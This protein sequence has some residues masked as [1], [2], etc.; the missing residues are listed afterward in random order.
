M[1]R[2]V[3]TLLTSGCSHAL[4]V[5][6][7]NEEP[8]SQRP[9]QH[10]GESQPPRSTLAMAVTRHSVD[11][12]RCTYSGA[13]GA[14]INPA[15]CTCG[16]QQRAGWL[17]PLTSASHAATQHVPRRQERRSTRAVSIGCHQGHIM[18]VG[19]TWMYD[20]FCTTW[21]YDMCCRAYMSAHSPAQQP[22]AR[23][24]RRCML[25]VLQQNDVRAI[26]IA[27]PRAQQHAVTRSGDQ[28]SGAALVEDGVVGIDGGQDRPVVKPMPHERLCGAHSGW[29]VWAWRAH[30]P[31]CTACAHGTTGTV[32][33][34]RIPV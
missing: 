22:I 29:W 31:C 32:T 13:H 1:S 11:R 10:R 8:A 15:A 19:T 7:S 4:V 28:P 34:S 30:D 5:C 18:Y 2:S 16:R 21:M 9:S 17:V 27:A 25:R 6:A 14:M 20:I 33:H 3:M 23:R 26:N 24:G 12:P